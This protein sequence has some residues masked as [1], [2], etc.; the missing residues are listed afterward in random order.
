MMKL[1]DRQFKEY[2]R[3]VRINKTALFGMMIIL[4]IP[5]AQAVDFG[6]F[7]DVNYR[8]FSPTNRERDHRLSNTFAQGQFDLYGTQKIDPVTRA[9]FELVFEDGGDGY[10]VDLERL[11]IA[12]DLSPN[13]SIGAGRFHT[14][15]GYWNTA[16][17]HGALIQDTVTRPTFL[18]FE[19]GYGAIIPMHVIGVMGNGKIQTAGGSFDFDMMV[20][21]STSINTDGRVA[22]DHEATMDVNSTVDPSDKKVVGIKATYKLTATPLEVGAFVLN[23]P[24]VQSGSSGTL[25]NLGGF[26]DLTLPGYGGD[27]VS[28]R[29]VGEHFRY[30]TSKFNVLG[31]SYS[32]SNDSKVDASG[33]HKASAYFIQFGY[34]VTDN[35]EPIYRYENVDFSNQDPYFQILG[36]EEG[37]RHVFDLRYDI[38]ET[39]ALKFEISRFLPVNSGSLNAN[40]LDTNKSYTFYSLQWAFLLL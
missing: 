24:V 15:G 10:G 27:L 21:N 16:Y 23:N 35:L 9:F 28:Q 19:D 31:E 30:A 40:G 25:G 39:N 26:P 13:F 5:A 3:M 17:H 18:N 36:T 32:L 4:G 33:K 11:Y 37:G 8:G 1:K 34:H 14:P 22:G 2:M 38:S 12:R 20:G 6:A 29:V 7:G